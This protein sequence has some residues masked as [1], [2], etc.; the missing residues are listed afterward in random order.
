MLSL[1]A[2]SE[3]I[4]CMHSLILSTL[5]HLH[6]A[7]LLGFLNIGWVQ[8]NSGAFSGEVSGLQ[9]HE[10]WS[11]LLT[12]IEKCTN[13]VNKIMIYQ[14][15]TSSKMRSVQVR[16]TCLCLNLKIRNF[17]GM[18]FLWSLICSRTTMLGKWRKSSSLLYQ[19]T[20]RV[21]SSV[22]CLTQDPSDTC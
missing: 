22:P 19:M 1:M 4:N 12:A 13:R 10:R 9:E 11:D 16:I 3:V 17:C 6:Y 5:A 14:V 8:K 21:A 2:G 20:A 7:V 18:G 15:S